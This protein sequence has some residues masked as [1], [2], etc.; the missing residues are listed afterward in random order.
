LKLWAARLDI[1]YRVLSAHTGRSDDRSCNS[2]DGKNYTGESEGVRVRECQVSRVTV[3]PSCQ[4]ERQQEDAETTFRYMYV[5]CGPHAKCAWEEDARMG[6]VP[7]V[8]G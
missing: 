6:T 4:P 3:E 5:R 2:N 8:G 1:Q 7:S